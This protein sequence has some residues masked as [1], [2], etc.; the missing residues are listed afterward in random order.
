REVLLEQRVLLRE[1]A[2]LRGQVAVRRELDLQLP[3]GRCDLASHGGVLSLQ[4]RDL[5]LQL[6]LLAQRFALVE[7]RVLAAE[8]VQQPAGTRR[9]AGQEREV[10]PA[11][12]PR[13]LGLD[14]N[15]RRSDPE[16]APEAPKHGH[17]SKGTCSMPV[18]SGKP[19]M[20]FMFCTA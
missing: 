7:A 13:N 5:F 2:N 14:G 12:I 3:L 11:P 4:T 8:V 20:R 10:E 6:P 9:Q 18:V 1:V 19:N 15:P 16:P 17:G